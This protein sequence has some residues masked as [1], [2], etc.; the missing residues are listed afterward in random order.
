MKIRKTALSLLALSLAAS[1]SAQ[2]TVKIGAITSLT[3]RFATFGKMTEAEWITGLNAPKG[4]AVLNRKLYV[5]DIDQ[6]IE[7]DI[8]EG[9]ITGL[10]NIFAIDTDVDSSVAAISA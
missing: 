6:L 8:K 7:I 9:K 10:D 3:G 4:M 1:A 2:A 5:T